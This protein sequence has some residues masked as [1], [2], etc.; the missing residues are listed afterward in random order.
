MDPGHSVVLRGLLDSGATPASP[1]HADLLDA[2]GVRFDALRR[3][4]ADKLQAVRRDAPERW[5]EAVLAQRLQ[6]AGWYKP[7]PW[8]T[9]GRGSRKDLRAI[10][11]LC[12]R[13]LLAECERVL[14]Q[15]QSRCDHLDDLASRQWLER[16]ME[17]GS[18]IAAC[19]AEGLRPDE[20]ERLKSWRTSL[21]RMGEEAFCSALAGRWEKLSAPSRTGLHLAAARPWSTSREDGFL[22]FARRMAD[23]SQALAESM[24]WLSR[25]RWELH[26]RA[27]APVREGEDA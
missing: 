27:L 1:G 22:G 4:I 14:V 3:E 7:D 2:L 26:L 8:S 21:S 25:S 9:T 12:Y 11:L 24:I 15:C 10:Y 18:R 16:P 6:E 17:E 20:A 19:L 13:E 5:G 23:L